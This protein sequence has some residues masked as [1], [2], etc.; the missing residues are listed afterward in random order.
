MTTCQDLVNETVRRLMPS[1]MDLSCELNGAVTA[2]TDSVVLSG[3]VASAN[4][5]S[6][7]M[8]LSV[9]L[10][11]MKVFEWTQN[12]LTAG[13][14]RGTTGSTAASHAGGSHVFINPKFTQFDIMGALNEELDA[15][16][17]PTV[18]FQVKT[19]TITYN[20]V[21]VGYDF[22][23]QGDFYD[24]LAVR[25]KIAPPTHNYLPIRKWSVLPNMTD[26]TYPSG[27]T[28]IL[29]DGGWPGLPMHVWYSCG[30]THLT[31]LTQNVQTIA[32]L[33]VTANDIPPI[34]AAI[35]LVVGREVKRNFIESQPD[36]RKAPE[37]PP[38]SVMK[39]I[40]GLQSLY[41]RR[42]DTEAAKLHR[43]Y[44]TL[45]VR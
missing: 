25:Y 16:S 36:P 4:T 30:F 40:D 14:W 32:G 1:Q 9:G 43:K 13:V 26:P 24:V 33:P 11:C 23:V 5:V 7:G 42:I 15:L 18:L 37:T 22:P 3:S 6:P 21:F 38:G 39:S 8:V 28:L 29:Y 12:S 41:L 45:R 19:L 44:A 17:G 35:R 10:E 20:P 27:W 34:G 31:S 2:T